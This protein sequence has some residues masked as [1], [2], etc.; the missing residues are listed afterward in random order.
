L[1]DEAVARGFERVAS[2]PQMR[3]LRRLV[4]ARAVALR[5]SGWAVDLG[6]GPG[7]L[8]VR[9]AQ[10]APGLKV[11]GVDLAPGMLAAGEERAARAGVADRVVFRRGDAADIP[12]PGESVDLVVSTL[13]LHHWSDPLAVLN[14]VARVLR[15]G[16]SYLIVDLRRDLGPPPWL[17]LW[18]ATH[19]VVPRALRRAGEPLNSR[20]AAYT[21]LEAAEIAGRSTLTGWRVSRGP[22]WLIIE[23]TMALP[24]S[25]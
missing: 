20:N 9:L 24:D 25:R 14:E 4:A 10:A 2:M 22:L 8:A 3:L 12:L 16:G 17:L 7:H 1:D 18:F 19:V 15:P 11:I 21:P 6:C 13:S 23:G 5:P